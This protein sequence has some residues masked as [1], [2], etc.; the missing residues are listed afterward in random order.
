MNGIL[1][2]LG[3]KF[4][5]TFKHLLPIFNLMGEDEWLNDNVAFGGT[6]TAKTSSIELANSNKIKR[7]FFN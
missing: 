3:T 1:I 5:T 6:F 7:I 4:I 2:L